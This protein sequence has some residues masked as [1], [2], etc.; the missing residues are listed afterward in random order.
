MRTRSFLTATVA[1][2]LAIVFL[3]ASSSPLAQG[4]VALSGTATSQEEGKMEGVV[5]NARR[6]GASFTVSVVSDAEG[7][8]S[9]PRTHLVS[10]SY[11]LTIRAVGYDLVTTGAVTVATEQPATRDLTLQKTKDLASQLSS[12]EW[13]MSM[14]GTPKEKNALVHQL[15]SCAYCHTYERI[16]K[17]TISAEHFVPLIARMSTYFQDGTAQSRDGRGRSV[18]SENT[19]FAEQGTMWGQ[20]P[21]VTRVELGRYLATVNLSGGR[22]TWPYELKTLP[23]PTGAATRVIITQYDMPRRDTV[24]H[25][26]EVD[27]TGTPWYGDQTANYIGKLDPTTGIFTDYPL[28]PLPNGRVGGVSDVHVDLEDRLWFPL[29]APEGSSH[30]GSPAMFDPKTEK[31]TRLEYPENRAVQFIAR[32]PDGKIWMNSTNTFIRID[33]TT[34]KVDRNFSFNAKTEGAPPGPHSFYQLGV[35]SKGDAYGTDWLGSY[36]ARIDGTTGAMTFFETPT[37]NAAPRRGKIDDQ[38]RFWFAEY[39]GDRIGMFDTKTETFKE[40]P[41]PQYSTPYAASIPDRNGYVYATS[42][43]AERVFRLNPETGE[44]IGYQIPTDFDSKEIIQVMDAGRTVFW[45]ANTRSAR[46]IRVVPLD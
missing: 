44:V 24:P 3:M 37:R 19:A 9:F 10:G 42:N 36:I 17:S 1:T 18:R 45:M 30:F 12:L 22:T 4:V 40:W 34:M 11:V 46:L 29:T 43:M 25:D 27:S 33:P 21:P 41:T 5:V 7:R 14:P 20:N 16:M 39:N 15:L 28:P 32:G 31:L 38:D 35:N 8:Y 13:A 26:V 2:A 6:D 23:R